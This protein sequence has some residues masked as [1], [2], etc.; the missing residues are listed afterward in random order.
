M[1]FPSA[2]SGVVASSA[3]A[4]AQK[5][6][7]LEPLVEDSL[8]PAAEEDKVLVHMEGTQVPRA[9]AQSPEVGHG[10]PQH[11]DLPLLQRR[12]LQLQLLQGHT[13]LLLRPRPQRQQQSKRHSSSRHSK[14][15]TARAKHV[16]A[17]QGP[18]L[19][20]ARAPLAAPVVECWADALEALSPPPVVEPM[21]PL[22]R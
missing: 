13:A 17:P 18:A 11:T 9:V 21:V 20:R 1:Q 16:A 4:Q 12:P 10:K 15:P 5:G 14:R 8:E 3:L 22:G 2:L 6:E 7:A 19:D